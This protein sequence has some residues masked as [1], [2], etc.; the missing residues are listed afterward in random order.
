MESVEQNKIISEPQA[1]VFTLPDKRNF[2]GMVKRV[3]SND[4]ELEMDNLPEEPWSVIER[5][6]AQA[7]KEDDRYLFL[8]VHFIGSSRHMGRAGDSSTTVFT[9]TVTLF[10]NDPENPFS[11]NVSSISTNVENLDLWLNKSLF[12]FHNPMH[13]QDTMDYE[14]QKAVGE[15]DFKGFRLSLGLSIGG[16]K[17]SRFTR[18]VNLRQHA[19]I[20]LYDDKKDQHYTKFVEALRS[21]ER[22]IGL[23][24]RAPVTSADIDVTSKDFGLTAGKAKK[25]NIFPA[26][27]ILLSN[28]KP[29]MP[30]LSYSDELAFTIDQVSDFQQLLNRWTELEKDIMPMVDLFLSS[31]SGG[32]L[33]LEN[34]FLNR[35]QAI[36]G[37]HRA[38]RPGNKIPGDEYEKQINGII[39]KFTGKD[40]SLVKRVLKHGNQMSL[41][42]R[43]KKLDTELKLLGIPT[44]M[45]CDF[46]VVANTRNYYSHYENDITNI[47][48]IDKFGELTYQSGQMLFALLL[49]ELGID[50]AIVKKAISRMRGI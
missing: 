31:V 22:L 15:Y 47:C 46:D 1:V 11:Q 19:H 12:T 10:T 2:D 18:G 39:E 38:Y 3:G 7:K 32:S 16:M 23:A 6:E 41:A 50:K 9:P 43:L 13:M 42:E 33:V 25:P 14:L 36:E 20:S 49:V 40:R 34:I 8:D 5:V 26:Y 4:F 48:T 44:I 29:S 35:I 21:L 45:V 17:F 27:T 24:F 28:V 30:V 37:F